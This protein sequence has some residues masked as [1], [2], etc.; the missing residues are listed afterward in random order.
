MGVPYIPANVD[1]DT[2]LLMIMSMVLAIIS[3]Y[4]AG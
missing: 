2:T 3:R 4:G 1:R